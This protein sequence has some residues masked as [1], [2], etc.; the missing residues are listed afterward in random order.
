MLRKPA[1]EQPAGAFGGDL[2][3]ALGAQER[4]APVALEI[5]QLVERDQTGPALAPDQDGP[6]M[7]ELRQ[8]QR[9]FQRGADAHFELLPQDEPDVLGAVDL[10]R[11]AE[12]VGQKDDPAGGDKLVEL[13][14]ERDPVSVP[15]L[16]AQ[17]SGVGRILPAGD[18]AQQ[19]SRRGEALDLRAPPLQFVL[20]KGGE[21]RAVFDCIVVDR[22]P[23]HGDLLR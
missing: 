1:F 5:E 20:H 11:V 21:G 22:D 17:K 8:R 18:I 16:H 10:R 23:K 19:L 9:L 13:L 15:E 14:R 12:R 7:P 3:S 4:F 2:F 6:V